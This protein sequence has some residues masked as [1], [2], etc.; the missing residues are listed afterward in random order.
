MAIEFPDEPEDEPAAKTIEELCRERQE[1][2]S[3]MSRVFW[4]E[5]EAEREVRE[6]EWQREDDALDQAF[7]AYWRSAL[8]TPNRLK[9]L[10]MEMTR[11]CGYAVTEEAAGA[12]FNEWQARVEP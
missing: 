8:P 12:R 9:S 5:T 3:L 10:V 11:I 6:S 1:R 4:K 2:S 7:D